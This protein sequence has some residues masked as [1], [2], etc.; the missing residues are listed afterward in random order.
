MTLL[1]NYF[2]CYCLCFALV[3]CPGSTVW[4]ASSTSPS[5]KYLSWISTAQNYEL[6]EYLNYC[7][8]SFD[9]SSEVMPLALGDY[10]QITASEAVRSHT[11]YDCSGDVVSFSYYYN[12]DEGWNDILQVMTVYTSTGV[13]Y[14]SD[15]TWVKNVVVS[16]EEWVVYG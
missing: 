7:G 16:R 2:L 3:F 14:E 15:L 12:A 13:I 5:S 6:N 4:G 8:Y 1:K 10:N 9:I 11:T